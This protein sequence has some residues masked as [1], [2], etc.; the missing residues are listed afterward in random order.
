MQSFVPRLSRITDPRIVRNLRSHP[1]PEGADFRTICQDLF[2][3]ATVS[4][5]I[6][7]VFLFG[8]LFPMDFLTTSIGL[9]LARE[10]D[11]T[12]LIIFRPVGRL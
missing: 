6:V 5:S 4:N 1:F 8:L 12:A 3:G 9:A 11:Q 2:A 10:P 7:S